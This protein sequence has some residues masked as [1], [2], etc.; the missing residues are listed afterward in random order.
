MDEFLEVQQTLKGPGTPGWWDDLFPK[1]TDEQAASLQQAA[2]SKQI[3]HRT[4]SVVLSKW[5]HKVSP[6]QVGHWRRTYVR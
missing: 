5:G 2:E 3:S 4:I 1:L 6:A